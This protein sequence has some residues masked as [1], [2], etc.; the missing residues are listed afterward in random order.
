MSVDPSMIDNYQNKQGGGHHGKQGGR[1]EQRFAGAA[2]EVL[3]GMS[4][5]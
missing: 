5:K 4:K 2:H 1:H 3:E